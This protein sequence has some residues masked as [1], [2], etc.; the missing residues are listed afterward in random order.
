MAVLKYDR[1]GFER[2]IDAFLNGMGLSAPALA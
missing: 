2:Q 1:P